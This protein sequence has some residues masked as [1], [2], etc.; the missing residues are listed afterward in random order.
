MRQ[1]PVL[2]AKIADLLADICETPVG[3][4]QSA[5]WCGAYF[6]ANEARLAHQ[7]GDY[8][9]ARSMLREAKSRFKDFNQ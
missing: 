8:R 2:G 6:F 3:L 4:R 7:E 5:A 9:T 1:A